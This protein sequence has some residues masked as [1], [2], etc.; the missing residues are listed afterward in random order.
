MQQIRALMSQLGH[1]RH[2]ELAQA[3]SACPPIPDI[4]LH[5]G[6]PTTEAM[7]I[8]GGAEPLQKALSTCQRV[9]VSTCY[10]VSARRAR[11]A[12]T[13]SPVFS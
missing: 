3:T 11:D 2:F 10:R 8:C 7:S 6:D 1:S 5:C 13:E 9:N 12:S 4:S